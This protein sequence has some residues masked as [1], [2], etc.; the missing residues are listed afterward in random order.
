MLRFLLKEK[1]RYIVISTWSSKARWTDQVAVFKIVKLCNC[2]LAFM[3]VY[4]L[5]NLEKY[6]FY[7]NLMVGYLLH[8]TLFLLKRTQL[9]SEFE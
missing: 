3:N 1:K 2:L 9:K 6:F 5:S 7:L 8:S 4:S